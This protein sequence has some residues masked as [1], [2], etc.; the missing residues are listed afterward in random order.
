[1][2]EQV[3][4]STPI[5]RNVN[6]NIFEYLVW[7]PTLKGF[8][9]IQDSLIQHLL[10]VREPMCKRACESQDVIVV[11]PVHVLVHKYTHTSKHKIVYTILR[12]LVCIYVSAC[13]CICRACVR[14]CKYVNTCTCVLVYYHEN[15]TLGR[16]GGAASLGGP[17][18]QQMG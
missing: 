13:A 17:G 9:V 6:V 5:K 1:M 3:L 12:L 14:A 15:C 16:A 7:F 2:G 8:V 4:L 18:G 10:C 11:M